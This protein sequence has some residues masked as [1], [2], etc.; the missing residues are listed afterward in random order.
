MWKVR[1]KTKT[2][3]NNKWKTAIQSTGNSPAAKVPTSKIAGN[4]ATNHEKKEREKRRKEE[5]GRRRKSE[6]MRE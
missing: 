6:R 4:K 5:E 2:K 3:C 1:K